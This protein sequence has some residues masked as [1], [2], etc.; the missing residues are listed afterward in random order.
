MVKILHSAKVITPHEVIDDGA[1]MVSDNGTILYVGAEEGAPPSDDDRLDLKGLILTAGFND[2]HTHGGKGVTFGV[3]DLKSELEAYSRWVVSSGVTGFLLSIAAPDAD[4][5]VKLISAYVPVLKA[6][7]PG[8]EALGLHL[9]GPFLTKEKKG[10]FNPA[11]LRPPAMDEAE[12]YLKAGKGWIRQMTIAPENPGAAEIAAHCRRQGVV[13]AIG[14]TNT[15]Y[16]TASAALK[17]DFTHV[18]HTFNAQSGF[19]HRA[20]G[21]FGAILTSDDITAELIA[22]TI[23][24]HPGAMKLLLRCLGKDRVAL[25]T[26]AMAG[27]GLSDGDYDL[28]GQRVF[29]RG[30]KATLEN[31]TIAGST[32]LLNQCVRNIVKEVGVPMQSAL[33][34]A[35]YNPARAIGMENKVGSVS[36]GRQA[37]LTVL[38]EDANV[39]LTMVKGQIVFDEL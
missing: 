12:A 35:N 17:G 33:Q 20:P 28:V 16:A 15:D 11:W 13:A 5:L 23:H 37:N 18:T 29:V 34:M 14:H 7:L 9:E 26:D 22:D 4:S 30:G 6:G 38:D 1:V 10:A 39:R 8:A 2:I 31:G 21:V 19:D 32:A 25:I 36:E 27:A 3:G 24:V